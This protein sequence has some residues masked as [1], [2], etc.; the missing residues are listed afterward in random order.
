[1]VSGDF[2]KRR[3]YS[4]SQEKK[5]RVPA[6][7]LARWKNVK[8]CSL[9]FCISVSGKQGADLDLRFSNLAEYR[10]DLGSFPDTNDFIGLE[11]GF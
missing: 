3:V 1:M 9:I 11:F 7:P 4:Q 8:P 10:D 6:L 2:G 5:G